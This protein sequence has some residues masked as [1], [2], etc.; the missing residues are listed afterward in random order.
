MHF[1][2]SVRAFTCTK[3]VQVMWL[4]RRHMG[5]RGAARH[6]CTTSCAGEGARCIFLEFS[7]M[8]LRKSC[9]GDVPLNASRR[10][11]W[12]YL[13]YGAQ[14]IHHSTWTPSQGSKHVIVPCTRMFKSPII[15]RCVSAAVYL[16]QLSPANRKETQPHQHERAQC[17][18]RRVQLASKHAE[19][20]WIRGIIPCWSAR[21]GLEFKRACEVRT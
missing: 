2:S 8:Y 10:M 9:A 11:S 13:V 15:C 18:L 12:A 3:V 6:T 17:F 21:V 7:S 14:L 20:T 1:S 4:G 19:C 5:T 16:Q